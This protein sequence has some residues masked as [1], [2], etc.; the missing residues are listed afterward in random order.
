MPEIVD[1]RDAACGS[2]CFRTAFDAL[3]GRQRLARHPRR[4]T[5]CMGGSKRCKSVRN[6]VTTRHREGNGYRFP[7]A[8]HGIESNAVRGRFDIASMNVCRLVRQAVGERA[9]GRN[10]AI[11]C[12]RLFIVQI[13]H[14]CL[15]TIHEIAEKRTKLIQRLVIEGD[16]VQHSNLGIVVRD[17]A[18]AL[19][20]FADKEILVAGNGTGEG[21]ICRSKVLH[22]GAVENRRA[23]VGKMQNPAEHARRCRFPASA[24]DRD[25]FPCTIEQLGQQCRAC[26]LLS[27][28]PARGLDVGDSV[29]HCGGTHEDLL[30]T[31]NPA[32]VLCI[33]SEPQGAQ[34]LELLRGAALVE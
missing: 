30:R 32:T 6:I 9:T 16:I 18:V 23:H 1:Y 3:E 28:D 2:D 26:N 14:A 15:G 13:E 12:R 27:T 4:H 33:K 11:E 5:E 20:D 19:V 22:D 21:K 10:G 31:G 34:M 29:F 25:A 7:I 8:H 17:R 24:G